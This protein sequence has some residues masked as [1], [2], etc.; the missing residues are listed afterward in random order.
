M[1]DGKPVLNS[2]WVGNTLGFVERLCL[3]SAL[4]TGHHFKLYSY[5]P[6]KLQG[7]PDGV[8]LCDA[9]EI[10]PREKLISYSDTGA[11][12]LGAN[13]WRYNLLAKGHGRW[14]DMDLILLKRFPVE[15]EYVF[16]WEYAG[17]INNAVMAAPAGSAFVDDLLSIP[18]PNRRPPWFGPK[19]SLLFYLERLKKGH[20]PLEDMP[21]GTYAA[22][23]VTYLVKKHKLEQFTLPPRV[24]YP[25][26]W[27]DARKLY[28]PA[29]EIEAMLAEDTLTVHMWH[30]SLGELKQAPPPAGSYMAKVAQRFGVE[31][32]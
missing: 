15:S 24:F 32:L 28:G 12:A 11:V 29:E 23:L 22:G 6:D 31:F 19:R 5:E 13:F 17:W 16:G 9:A 26:E 2:L 4:G 8:E 27:K 30:S 1:S 25:V 21:W 10:M 20:I 14:V 7:V 3:M 18:Q